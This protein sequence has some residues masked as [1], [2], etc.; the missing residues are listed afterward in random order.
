MCPRDVSRNRA[1]PHSFGTESQRHAAVAQLVGEVLDQ[2][3]VD[4]FKHPRPRLDQRHS[5]VERTKDRRVFHADDAGANHCQ[6]ARQLRNFDDL[7]AVEDVTA[8]K[9]YAGRTV[10]AG[11][12]G[13]QDPFALEHPDVADLRGDLDPVGAKKTRCPGMRLHGVASELVLQHIDLVIERHVQPRHQVLGGDVLLH[14]IGAAVETALAPA[15]QV[16]HGLA[17]GLRRD[18][19]GV[20]GH[21]TDAAALLHHQDR[22]AQ[23]G[24][25]DRGTAASGAAADDNE[26]KR[27]HDSSVDRIG[28]ACLSQSDSFSRSTAA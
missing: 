7:V 21:A 6:A 16:Q 5:H 22:A 24:G 26:I 20:H 27:V 3:V 4:E 1:T 13:D 17:Q 19:A 25:L 23:F 9:R 10:R 11:A 14:P 18:G 28:P 12:D 2:L 15:G 8:V